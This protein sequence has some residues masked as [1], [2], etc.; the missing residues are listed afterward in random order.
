MWVI[1]HVHLQSDVVQGKG[2][3][4][5]VYIKEIK[6]GLFEKNS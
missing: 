4:D 3:I 5:L 6:V 1:I 2:R